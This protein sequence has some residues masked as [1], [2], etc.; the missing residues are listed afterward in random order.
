MALKHCCCHSSLLLEQPLSVQAPGGA[1]RSGW[2]TK[3]K[4]AVV[5]GLAVLFGALVA[6]VI[7]YRGHP[8]TTE[9]FR[10]ASEWPSR[11]MEGWRGRLSG[12]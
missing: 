2:T 4:A 5:I 8:L 1:A 9:H 6:L 12:G 7:N 10:G 3:R 11:W